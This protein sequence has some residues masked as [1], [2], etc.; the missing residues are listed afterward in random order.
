[1][2]RD[3][4]S[5]HNGCILWGNRVVIPARGQR[6]LLEDLHTAHPG[7]VRMKNLARSY[8]WWPGLDADIEGKVKSCE[9]CQLHRAAP[10]AAP[11]HPWEWPEKP[12]SRIHI[13]HAGPFMGQLFLIVI[14]AYSKWIEVYPTSSTSAT[15]TIE[16]LRRA[17]ATHGLPEMVVSDNGTGFAS[18]EFGNFMTKNGILH[19]KTAPRHPSSNGLVERSVRI[20]KEGMKKLEGSGGTVHTKLSRFLLAYRSTPQTT[21]GVTPAEL[22][23]NRR[24]RTR[25]DLIRPDVRHREET[26]QL[27]QKEQHDNTRTAQ[28]FAEG[29]KVLVKNFSSGPKWKKAHIESRTGPLSYTVKYEDGVVTRRHVD[30]LLKRHDVPS[31]EDDVLPDSSVHLSKTRDRP[32]QKRNKRTWPLRKFPLIQGS[33]RQNLRQGGLS[34]QGGV[35]KGLRDCLSV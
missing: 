23:F 10:A 19:V 1:M 16:I 17:F 2:R 30:H 14:D 35:L 25:L 3:E 7:I 4:L 31:R 33:Q 13:D 8:L 15:A 29:D 12:W 11:L 34:A 21:T 27:S 32:Q 22:L 26:Q 9:V 6:Q 5:T 20:F 24:L 28:Q 18:E